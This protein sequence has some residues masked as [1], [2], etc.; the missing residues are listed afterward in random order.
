MITHLYR[1]LLIFL[2]LD[3]IFAK[4]LKNFEVFGTLFSKG[5]LARFFQRDFWHAFFKGIFGTLFS[6]GFLARFF[7]KSVYMRF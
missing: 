6:K 3:S 1:L 4:F 7:L 2:G 5:F